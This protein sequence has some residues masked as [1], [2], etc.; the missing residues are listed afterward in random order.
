MQHAIQTKLTEL[1]STKTTKPQTESTA[2]ESTPK[3]QEH[4]SL[5]ANT[6]NT[7]TQEGI[8]LEKLHLK[9][10]SQKQGIA[11]VI[12]EAEQEDLRPT[13]TETDFKTDK[14]SVGKTQVDLNL[15]HL[16]NKLTK[17][18]TGDDTP[19]TSVLT[20]LPE[21]QKNTKPQKFRIP[22]RLVQPDASTNRVDLNALHQFLTQISPGWD[23]PF[24]FG[25]AV[26]NQGHAVAQVGG[27][28]IMADEAQ[29]NNVN[30]Y[31]PVNAGRESESNLQ[32]HNLQTLENSGNRALCFIYATIMGLT[33][34]NEDQVH[35]MVNYVAQ[36]AKV[37]QDG[38]IAMGTGIANNVIG[39]LTQIYG[40]FQIIEL[41]Q[42]ADGPMI[43]GRTHN[44]NGALRT[45]LIRN[46]GGHFDAYVPV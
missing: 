5:L 21:I 29:G 46:T 20:A 12:D 36:Q 18:E 26:A 41:M 19:S 22:E 14:L 7:F 28:G 4:L 25:Q 32:Q 45:V 17:A 31:M 40:P 9:H 30:D 24:V 42:S 6:L 27:Q 43:S 38:Y 37:P 39:V 15:M 3:L 13:H 16:I 11:P 35:D 34:Q 10:Q 2:P 8:S 23:Q 33:G 1:N 44:D